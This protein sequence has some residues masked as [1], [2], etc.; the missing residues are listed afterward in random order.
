MAFKV[1]KLSDWVLAGSFITHLNTSVNISGTWMWLHATQYAESCPVQLCQKFT[2][3]SLSWYEK[4][5]KLSLEKLTGNSNWSYFGEIIF[6]SDIL[7]DHS[8]ISICWKHTVL[9]CVLTVPSSVIWRKHEYS[10]IFMHI[11]SFT[12][13]SESS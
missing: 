7:Y 2:T 13:A 6:L 5:C 3:V 11:N 8:Y 4:M 9:V 1:I 12:L 10:H